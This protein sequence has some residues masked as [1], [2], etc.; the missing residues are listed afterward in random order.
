MKKVNNRLKI[1]QLSRATQ[2]GALV[3]IEKL[4]Q[5]LK[6]YREALG[7]TQSQMAKKLKIRQPVISRIEEDAASS[8]LKT[9]LRIAGVLECDFLGVIR[10]SQPLETKIRRQAE[11]V[12]KKIIFRTYANMAMEKQAPPEEAYAGQLKRLIDELAGKP[13]P[14]LWEE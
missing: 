4:G 9:I 10:S 2:K 13:G 1:D 5:R 8:S 7:M 14:E 11:K 12:A 6:D 3:P